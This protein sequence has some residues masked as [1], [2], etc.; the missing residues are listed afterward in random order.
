[1][2]KMEK[3]GKM[4]KMKTKKY[5]ENRKEHEIQQI[6]I[7]ALRFIGWSWC[8]GTSE[9]TMISNTFFP[10]SLSTAT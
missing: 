10:N 8:Y 6:W 3:M 1:M 4:E 7:T 5:G 2:E 9:S